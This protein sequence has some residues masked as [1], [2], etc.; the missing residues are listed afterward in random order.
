MLTGNWQADLEGP[1]Q[2]ASDQGKL[3]E[4]IK[5]ELA[6]LDKKMDQLEYV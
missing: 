5:L 3:C 4:L 2:K 6:K 1:K